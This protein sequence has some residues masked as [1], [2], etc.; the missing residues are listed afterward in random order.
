MLS[1]SLVF[2]FPKAKREFILQLDTDEYRDKN[3]S[4]AEK[5]KG[6]MILAYFSRILT[7]AERKYCHLVLVVDDRE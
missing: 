5:E 7:K 6:K 2:S 3:S 1:S 4:V